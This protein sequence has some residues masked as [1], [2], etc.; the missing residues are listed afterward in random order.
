MGEHYITTVQNKYKQMPIHQSTDA[1]WEIIT[2]GAMN[3]IGLV[4]S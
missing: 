2:D 4:L 3:W 1:S